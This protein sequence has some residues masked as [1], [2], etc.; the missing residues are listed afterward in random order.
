MKD[1]RLTDALSPTMEAII[2]NLKLGAT[3]TAAFT[4]VGISKMTFYRWLDENVTFCDAVT[5][6]EAEAEISHTACIAHAA[7]EGNWQASKFWLE[8]RRPKEWREIKTIDLRDIPTDIL[9]SLLEGEDE[10]G[11]GEE[12]GSVT[13]PIAGE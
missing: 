6:A 8:R 11:I 10:E 7:K 12:E 9:V 3:R 1:L 2:A 13:T 5:R 4:S